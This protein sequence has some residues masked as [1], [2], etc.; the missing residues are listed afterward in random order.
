[1][2]YRGK[3]S[4]TEN[5]VMGRGMMLLSEAKDFETWKADAIASGE[6]K[7]AQL[8]NGMFA[9]VNK[10]GQKFYPEHRRSGKGEYP[11]EEQVWQL[12][13]R[14]H[15]RANS[16]SDTQA[17]FSAN[18]KEKY[19]IDVQAGGVGTET[20]L[21]FPN[22]AHGELGGSTKYTELGKW[23]GSQ[24]VSADYPD[25]VNVLNNADPAIQG[26][27]GPDAPVGQAVPAALVFQ[28]WMNSGDD[29][30]L[31]YA[32][33]TGS[34]YK[35]FALTEKGQTAIPGKNIKML[36][37]ADCNDST[38]GNRETGSTSDNARQGMPFSS[39]KWANA[40]D[41]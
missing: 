10:S 41:V 16:G 34:E 29:I 7:V 28:V 30:V 3:Y 33:K 38:V 12:G 8:D 2:K 39:L 24:F 11:T 6:Y 40:T 22:G 32:S 31:Q 26:T 17:T 13:H 20:D 9:R 5:L 23:D 37:V 1:M 21:Q 19:D 25:K 14:A 15:V 18:M 36:T 4:L 35:A 27:L